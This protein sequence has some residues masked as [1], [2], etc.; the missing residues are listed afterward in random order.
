MNLVK[1]WGD[2]GRGFGGGSRL[3]VAV[4]LVHA[5]GDV[6][7][8]DDGVEMMLLCRMVLNNCAHVKCG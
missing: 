1:I 8:K 4:A 3:L 2:G 6:A 7:V 5:D